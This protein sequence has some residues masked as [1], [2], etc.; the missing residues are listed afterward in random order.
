MRPSSSHAQA[1]FRLAE[2]FPNNVSWAKET[3]GWSVCWAAKVPSGNTFDGHLG[4]SVQEWSRCC[5]VVSKREA[6]GTKMKRCCWGSPCQQMCDQFDYV[7]LCS[8]RLVSN[9]AEKHG[10]GHVANVHGDWPTHPNN[11]IYGSAGA[12]YTVCMSKQP[13]KLGSTSSSS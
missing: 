4:C 2:L 10:A 12:K 13:V 6:G 11:I 7:M 5:Y 9:Y 3:I 8:S 1:P